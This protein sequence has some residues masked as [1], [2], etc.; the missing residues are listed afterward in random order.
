MYV[1]VAS[2][3]VVMSVCTS[4]IY[5]SDVAYVGISLIYTYNQCS[6]YICFFGI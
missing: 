1:Y 2:V 3:N 5:M 6:V 4:S